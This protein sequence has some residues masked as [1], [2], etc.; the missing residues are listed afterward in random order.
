MQPALVNYE[1]NIWFDLRFSVD[2][3]HI[4]L[5]I[6]CEPI[7]MYYISKRNNV[8]DGS[9]SELNVFVISRHFYLVGHYHGTTIALESHAAS[10]LL[11]L[12]YQGLVA[13]KIHCGLTVQKYDLPEVQLVVEV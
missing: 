8:G 5:T 2:Y 4:V 13:E 3:E 10:G 6:I 12:C 1:L 9:L 7:L 11:S